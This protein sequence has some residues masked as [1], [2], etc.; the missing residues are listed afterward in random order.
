MLAACMC[1]LLVSTLVLKSNGR[2][3]VPMWELIA[4]GGPMAVLISVGAAAIAARFARTLR[5]LR[6]S[7]AR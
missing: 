7:G 2:L 3:G 5:M 1:T 4:A 6:A